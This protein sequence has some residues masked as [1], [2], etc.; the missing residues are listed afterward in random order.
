[1]KIEKEHNR[2]PQ[3]SSERFIP[4]HTLKDAIFSGMGIRIGGISSAQNGFVIT[5]PGNRTYH[6]LIITISGNGKFLMED[7]TV[8]F[9]GPGDIFFSHANGQGHIH[10]PEAVPWV[11][12]WLQFDTAQNWLIPPFN[13]WG[14]IPGNTPDNALKL[15]GILESI[16]DEELFIRTE[17]NRLQRLYAELFMIYLQRE[18]HIRDN[19]RLNWY[20][21]R[22][23]QLW[24]A[25]AA[26]PNKIWT[27]EIMSR[28]VGLSRAQ[29]SRVCMLL[30]QKS[31]GEKVKEIRMEHVLSILMHFDCQ[32]SEAAERIGYNNLSNFSAAFKKYF[33]CSP[34]EARESGAVT[35][36]I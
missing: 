35:G 31:P 16:L 22:M 6:I 9:S 33:G 30:Y 34:R 26:S 1:M 28:F 14:L 12:L 5:R 15:C 25:V 18:L 13:D 10:Q 32:V 36:H 2:I 11:F 23:N 3:E 29:L 7:K 27:L 24:Q 8:V 17:A 20:W 21:N 19:G 4:S